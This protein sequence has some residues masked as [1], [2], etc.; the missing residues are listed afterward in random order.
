MKLV[1][2]PPPYILWSAVLVHYIIGVCL[3]A[4]PSTGSLLVL[5]GLDVPYK[6]LN[7]VRGSIGDIPYVSA[8][9]PAVLG[10]VLVSASTLAMLGLV[11]E[12]HLRRGAVLGALTPQYF[13][14]LSSLLSDLWLLIDAEYMGIARDRWVIAS[15][16]AAFIVM[17][18]LH[19]Y[20][21]LERY[22]VN[23]TRQ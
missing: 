17:S 3:V 1:I 14:I 5:S 23:W 16:L 7:G 4:S 19:T 8:S 2:Q 22:F 9:D 11:F 12:T 20:N 18:A 13:L 6:V 21:V 15:V 10:I